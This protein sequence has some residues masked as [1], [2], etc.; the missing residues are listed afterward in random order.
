MEWPGDAKPWP[1]AWAFGHRARGRCRPTTEEV[2]Q[3]VV[4]SQGETLV[5]PPIGPRP[6]DPMDLAMANGERRPFVELLESHADALHGQ[7]SRIINDL[8]D[9]LVA[10]YVADTLAYLSRML[11]PRSRGF[12]ARILSIRPANPEDLRAPDPTR[13]ES[14]PRQTLVHWVE[15]YRTT[16]GTLMVEARTIFR[17]LGVP[18][19]FKAQG[20]PI[21]PM[22]LAA[23][24]F[25]EE[26]PT[27]EYLRELF[28]AAA[29]TT[30]YWDPQQIADR[31]ALYRE[32]FYQCYVGLGVR[33]LQVALPKE[34]DR[35]ERIA[36]GDGAQAADS[37]LRM[38]MP[39]DIYRKRRLEALAIFEDLVAPVLL[40]T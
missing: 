10:Y 31:E 6:I 15:N 11:P 3:T 27:S 37:L 34:A 16:G 18:N 25:P 13:L 38:L 14:E 2:G 9:D 19:A 21:P 36:I 8:A 40:H 4:A 1:D 39:I 12:G 29:P 7:P 35:V 22:S 23:V 24:P 30:Y 32:A 28:V 20:L 33:L 26:W 17:H 5:I